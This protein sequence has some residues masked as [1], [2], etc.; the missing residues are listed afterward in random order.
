M[1]LLL[2]GKKI[3]SLSVAHSPATYIHMRQP[4]IQATPFFCGFPTLLSEEDAPWCN[5]PLII[6]L[7]HHTPAFKKGIIHEN[8]KSHFSK[9]LERA[10]ERER[11]R[12]VSKKMAL[13]LGVKQCSYACHYIIINRYFDS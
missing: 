10:R 11:G 6:D 7:L 9:Q 2:F 5:H 1:M 3:R 8:R 12:G 4:A 13:T